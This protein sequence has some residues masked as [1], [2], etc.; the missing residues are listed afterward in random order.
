MTF[1][2]AKQLICVLLAFYYLA[3]IASYLPRT[4][5]PYG[6]S[7]NSTL[8]I[9]SVL[10]VASL[11]CMSRRYGAFLCFTLVGFAVGLSFVVH[12]SEM[13]GQV[14]FFGAI[15]MVLGIGVDVYLTKVRIRKSKSL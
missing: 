12:K 14:L 3:L 2:Q 5:Q 6:I 4:D 11:V 15:G 9:W 1:L 8:A 13:F 7:K 10:F